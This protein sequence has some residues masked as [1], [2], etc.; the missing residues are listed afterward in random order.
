MTVYRG[1][2]V[3]TP[4]EAVLDLDIIM[5]F[6]IGYFRTEYNDL[7][8]TDCVFFSFLFYFWAHFSVGLPFNYF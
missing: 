6:Y 8:T 5:R 1:E 7:I 3:F 4:L 2:I